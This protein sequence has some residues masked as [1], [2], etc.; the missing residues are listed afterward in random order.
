MNFR[1]GNGG[2]GRPTNP[3]GMDLIEDNMNKSTI[4]P[5]L[6]SYRYHGKDQH[7]EQVGRIHQEDK[8]EHQE[9]DA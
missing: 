8:H 7:I 2:G 1:G 3:G 5:A 6:T 4:Y 9:H